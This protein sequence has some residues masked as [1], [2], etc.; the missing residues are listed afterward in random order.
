MTYPLSLTIVL[1]EDRA[2]FALGASGGHAIVEILPQIIVR[3][4]D[5]GAN[6]QDAV[7]AGRVRRAGRYGLVVDGDLDTETKARLATYGY[8]PEYIPQ[9]S[10]TLGAAQA[11]DVAFSPFTCD[12]AADSRRDE[13]VLAAA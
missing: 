8:W 12:G 4:I 9:P 3:L 1:D 5:R 11:I 2:R 6:V 10:P 13:S 7:S